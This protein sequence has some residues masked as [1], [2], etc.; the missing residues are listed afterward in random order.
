MR[1]RRPCLWK[2]DPTDQILQPGNDSEAADLVQHCRAFQVESVR[3]RPPFAELRQGS[4][5]G[6]ASV[7]R[8]P[9]TCRGNAASK[10][11][12]PSSG[13]IRLPISSDLEVPKQI[14]S[15]A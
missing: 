12:P 4:P 13:F 9:D 11:A 5:G 1:S 10:G 14:S 15:S 2:K 8:L 7:C 3:L 6:I